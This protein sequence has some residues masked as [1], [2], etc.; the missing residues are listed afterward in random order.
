MA[1]DSLSLYESIEEMKNEITKEHGWNRWDWRNW[2]DGRHGRLRRRWRER[3]GC[4]A[5]A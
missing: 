2:G 5:V 1:T 3:P 4:L